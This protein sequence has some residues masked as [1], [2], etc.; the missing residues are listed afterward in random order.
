MAGKRAWQA[1]SHATVSKHFKREIEP[2][3]SKTPFWFPLLAVPPKFSDAFVAANTALTDDDSE[4]VVYHAR[5]RTAWSQAF[6]DHCEAHPTAQISDGRL[7]LECVTLR[8]EQPVYHYAAN[9]SPAGFESERPDFLV[10]REVMPLKSGLTCD[11]VVEMQTKSERSDDFK[12]PDISQAVRYGYLVLDSQPLRDQVTICLC[13][14][15]LVQFVRVFRHIPDVHVTPSA[16]VAAPGAVHLQAGEGMQQLYSYLLATH[17][18]HGQRR[19]DIPGWQFT[20]MPPA[21]LGAGSFSIVLRVVDGRQGAALKLYQRRPNEN[22]LFDAKHITD[23]VAILDLLNAT[24]AST[25]VPQILARDTVLQFILLTPV[26]ER[27]SELHVDRDLISGLVEAVR[28][29]HKYCIHRDLRAANILIVPGT[30][31]TIKII[32]W[33]LGLPVGD[34]VHSHTPA[35][36]VCVQGFGVLNAITANEQYLYSH[37]EDLQSLVRAMY[38]IMNPEVN[39]T[40]RSETEAINWFFFWRRRLQ[41]RVPPVTALESIWF[42][43]M[44]A[45]DCACVGDYDGLREALLCLL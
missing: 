39:A 33:N 21:I 10:F 17:V 15:Q 6:P 25:H 28:A 41:Q 5:F 8:Q 34:L 13:T 1:S 27:L 30:P 31:R 42:W 11:G 44:R 12:A 19:I 22:M 37:K 24:P 35:G 20:A 40:K 2:N 3:I 26:G 7:C 23:E 32:D 38:L 4:N 9:S 45:E 14:L 16:I 18:T 43:W 36:A 29:V